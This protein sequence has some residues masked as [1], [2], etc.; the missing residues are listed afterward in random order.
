MA[1]SWMRLRM[2]TSIV[3]STATSS[4]LIA[5]T[6][7]SIAAFCKRDQAS[8][9]TIQGLLTDVVLALF[10]MLVLLCIF[11]PQLI[12]TS[13]S[14]PYASQPHR[15]FG[16]SAFN[17]QL[18]VFQVFHQETSSVIVHTITIFV[19]TLAWLVMIQ[20]T[21]GTVGTALVLAAV[22]VQGFSYGDAIFGL[23]NT[24]LHLGFAFLCHVIY[25]SFDGT[26]ALAVAKGVIF[27]SSVAQT[28]NHAFEPLPPSY[29]PDT[30][31]FDEGFGQPAWQLLFTNPVKSLAL[32][33]LGLASELEATSPGRFFTTVV[34]KMLYNCGYRS[35]VLL[36]AAQ[37]KE[38]SQ[39][40]IAGG[41]H[42][43]PLTAELYRW[44]AHECEEEDVTF[45][46]VE[47]GKEELV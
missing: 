32:M 20:G 37:A 39:T 29:N 18:L 12:A 22:S 27:W 2:A 44:A 8:L 3:L 41:W 40:I 45:I 9:T 26:T 35:A 10:L 1:V 34:Y 43:H 5:A 14:F 21:F 4:G 42:A 24:S 47:A 46:T 30:C 16:R 31:E 36:D 6:S 28:V 11:E 38:W 23:V 17:F 15:S 13:H 33:G 7:P 19:A 25:S